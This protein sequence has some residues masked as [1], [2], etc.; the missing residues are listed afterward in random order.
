MC[1]RSNQFLSMICTYTR[2]VNW[3][4]RMMTAGKHSLYILTLWL[5]LLPYI[6]YY[7]NPFHTLKLKFSTSKYYV[8]AT[9]LQFLTT[10]VCMSVT[11]SYEPLLVWPNDRAKR[12][13]RYP[14]SVGCLFATTMKRKDRHKQHY[15]HKVVSLL[16]G[17]KEVL[18]DSISPILELKWVWM[19]IFMR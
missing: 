3:F 12:S 8:V 15:F 9:L 2:A 19:M 18:F 17:Q 4:C 11:F 7:S 10:T 5:L 13:V 16:Y 1:E 6:I 14:S